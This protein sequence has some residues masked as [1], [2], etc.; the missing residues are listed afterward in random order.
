[1]VALNAS[2]EATG[3][4]HGAPNNNIGIH[5]HQAVT[6][7]PALKPEQI[8][9]PTACSASQIVSEHSRKRHGVH[10]QREIDTL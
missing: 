5:L 8:L 3:A 2:S 10:H 9:V 4:N 1:M 6:T 7:D